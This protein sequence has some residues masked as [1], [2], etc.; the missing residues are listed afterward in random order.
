TRKLLVHDPA[1]CHHQSTAA[2]LP[3]AHPVLHAA[4]ALDPAVD[5]LDLSAASVQGLVRQLL[6]QRTLLTAGCLGRREDF[7][8]LWPGRERAAPPGA[9]DR[10]VTGLRWCR[11]AKRHGGSGGD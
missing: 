3:Q 9:G 7:H 1:A 11:D 8:P 10:P 6:P 4:T 2:L 5:V